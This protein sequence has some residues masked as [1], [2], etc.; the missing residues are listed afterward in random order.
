MVFN[1]P[2]HK[3]FSWVFLREKHKCEVQYV[4][5]GPIARFP[6]D[7]NASFHQYC[8][9]I[10]LILGAR[11]RC[12]WTCSYSTRHINEVKLKI[13]AGLL[14]YG[15]DIPPKLQHSSLKTAMV[16]ESW[17]YDILYLILNLVHKG[18]NGLDTW[19]WSC[20]TLMGSLQMSNLKVPNCL[21]RSNLRCFSFQTCI[22][23]HFIK[24]FPSLSVNNKLLI[25]TAFLIK[26]GYQH[27]Q[28]WHLH[29][30]QFE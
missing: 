24:C 7:L 9:Y 16:F 29:P 10:L 1:E 4:L 25:N 15:Q 22:Y 19:K 28:Q 5:W 18:G 8:Q 3:S 27:I 17:N 13:L 11:N 20:N 21:I 6:I 26:L 12:I 23:L 14:K 2:F 30:V